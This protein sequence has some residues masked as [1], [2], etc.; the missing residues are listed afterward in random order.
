VED[1]TMKIVVAG[2]RGHIGAKL[3]SLLTEAGHEAVA[4][5]RA[6]GVDAVTA[7]GLGDALTGA[8][9]V[10]DVLNPPSLEP[11]AVMDFFRITTANLLTAEA[12]AGVGHHL[13]LSI[14]GADRLPGSPYVRA[15]V[16]Q[17]ELIAAGPV[18]W[19]VLRA[20]QFFEFLDTIGQLA[21]VDGT[22]HLSRAL[23][24]P[25]AADDV[26]AALADLAVAAPQNAIL[27]LGGPEPA[28]MNEVIERFWRDR[29]NPAPVEADDA[30]TYFG[31]TLDEK[32]LVTGPGAR[33][34]TTTYDEWI[35]R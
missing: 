29:D 18:P 7:D 4:A 8:D 9:A 20:T 30:A 14:V 27:E 3:V 34:G 12:V 28:P 21:L 2:G 26:A 5:S 35:K 1:D 10:V 16:A 23:I 6:T 13:L 15:K 22:A 17:E 11:D 24:Q 31:A 33:I 32:T 25:V 19:T